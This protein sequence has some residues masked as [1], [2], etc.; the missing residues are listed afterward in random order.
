MRPTPDLDVPGCETTGRPLGVSPPE[1]GMALTLSDRD[2]DAF[3]A[4]EKALLR[5]LEQADID[6]SCR[7]VLRHTEALFHANRS[8]TLV[9][10]AGRLPYVSDSVTK[11]TR[12]T[13]ERSIMRRGRVRRGSRFGIRLRAR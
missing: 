1:G 4:L 12:A 3:A 11:G 5:P 2:V 13:V 9:P 8:A 6:A 10:V 7:A